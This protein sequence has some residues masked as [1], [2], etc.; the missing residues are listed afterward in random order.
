ML[1]KILDACFISHTDSERS[2]PEI[3]IVAYLSVL[4][5][6]LLHAPQVVSPIFQ[7]R[8]NA[9]VLELQDQLHVLAFLVDIYLRKFFSLPSCLFGK[10]FTQN[11]KLLTN[12]TC[13]LGDMHRKTWAFALSSLLSTGNQPI[14]ERCGQ[15]LELCSDVLE[16]IHVNGDS[17]VAPA[18]DH[19]LTETDR[20]RA[21][22][23]EDE[24]CFS[25]FLH[26]SFVVLNLDG[27]GNEFESKRVCASKIE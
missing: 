17:P 18:S 10:L 11:W 8:V 26:N 5:R 21:L 3:V 16:E 14:L 15:I 7:S 24:V 6:A 12:N 23:C 27:K 19:K 22:Q 13:I 1:G 2:E 4:A 9:N 20:R 25:L